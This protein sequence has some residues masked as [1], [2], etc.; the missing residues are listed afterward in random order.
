ML[1]NR[2]HD[3]PM[4]RAVCEVNTGWNEAFTTGAPKTPDTIKG[5]YNLAFGDP[6]YI[7]F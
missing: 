5:E 7:V 2:Y 3:V 6:P 1:K 4:K